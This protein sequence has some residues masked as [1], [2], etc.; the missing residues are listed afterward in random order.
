MG[1]TRMMLG[2]DDELAAVKEL[3][4]DVVARSRWRLNRLVRQRL[5]IEDADDPT[6]HFI[7]RFAI[8]RQRVAH[9]PC[10]FEA[11]PFV[12]HLPWVEEARVRPMKGV[13][14]FECSDPVSV[15]ELTKRD[16]WSSA[17]S[18]FGVLVAFN[19]GSKELQFRDLVGG[20][21]FK[22][23]EFDALVNVTWYKSDV[24][25]LV[26]DKPAAYCASYM[27]LLEKPNISTFNTLQVPK[28]DGW[29]DLQ[30]SQYTGKIV[31]PSNLKL[32]VL[33]LETM[34]I[35]RD[36]HRNVETVHMAYVIP[37]GIMALV[38]T[39]KPEHS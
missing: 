37:K 30:L 28:C 1:W 26:H 7:L 4:W 27:N 31:Y 18:Q 25:A 36:R 22:V 15:D 11:C 2:M 35:K 33:D 24:I 5:F 21:V 13:L 8:T 32:V 19:D 12:T 23:G 20:T 17:L 10:E 29:S 34:K 39:F 9:R 16:I 14:G 38:F 6:F 3:D